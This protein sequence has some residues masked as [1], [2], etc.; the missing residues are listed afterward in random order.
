MTAVVRA[1]DRHQRDSVEI[2]E[3]ILAVAEELAKSTPLEHVTNESICIAADVSASV[4]YRRFPTREALL[5]ALVDRYVARLRATGLALVEGIVHDGDGLESALRRVV[6]ALLVFQREN[7]VLEGALFRHDRTRA[8]LRPVT[9]ALEDEAADLLAD[10]FGLA[11]VGRERLQLMV[12][13]ITA[14]T[15]K[16]LDTD[17]PTSV[18]SFQDDKLVEHLVELYAVWLAES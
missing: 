8:T 17:R 11:G 7:R 18:R 14:M 16:H 10:R 2:T 13:G 4:L 15:R 6:S 12:F 3:H 9:T 1:R 5:D